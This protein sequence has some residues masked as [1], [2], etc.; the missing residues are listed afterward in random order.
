MS[1]DGGAPSE[2]RVHTG[3]VARAE[4]PQKILHSLIASGRLDDLRW[5]DFSDYRSEVTKLYAGS[6][7]APVWLRDG[8]PTAQALEM[9]AVLQE[10]D[11]EALRAE[12]YDS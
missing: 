2:W 11:H 12:D 5:P 8:K 4:A 10:A 9:I 1:A 3:A 6:H 7:F